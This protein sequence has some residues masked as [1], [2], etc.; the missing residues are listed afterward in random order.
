MD[1]YE[2]TTD[3]PIYPRSDLPLADISYFNT[4]SW[5]SKDKLPKTWTTK[6][7]DRFY[8]PISKD[9]TLPKWNSE[10]FYNGIIH[11]KN[12]QDNNLKLWHFIRRR[13]LRLPKNDILIDYQMNWKDFTCSQLKFLSH[14][15][16]YVNRLDSMQNLFSIFGTRYPYNHFKNSNPDDWNDN[17]PKGGIP[18]SFSRY[19]MTAFSPNIFGSMIDASN[20]YFPEALG[21]FY[22]DKLLQQAVSRQAKDDI[23]RKR[24]HLIT[25][26]FD[27]I[28]RYC[29]YYE[30][31]ERPVHLSIH[32]DTHFWKE[33]YGGPYHHRWIYSLYPTYFARNISTINPR[34]N[35]PFDNNDLFHTWP[36]WLWL[37]TINSY[38]LFYGIYKLRQ[39]NKR[40]T[41]KWQ[42]HIMQDIYMNHYEIAQD[43]REFKRNNLIKYFTKWIPRQYFLGTIVSGIVLKSYLESVHLVE[44]SPKLEPSYY[45]KKNSNW[46]NKW[47]S[48]IENRFNFTSENEFMEKN[49]DLKHYDLSGPN[50]DT[51]I[52][53]DNQEYYQKSFFSPL[54]AAQN[55]HG[56]TFFGSILAIQTLRELRKYGI[57]RTLPRALIR[58]LALSSIYLAFD[59]FRLHPYEIFRHA[60]VEALY[61]DWT[62]IRDLAN[63]TNRNSSIFTRILEETMTNRTMSHS[64]KT[65]VFNTLVLKH[66]HSK[67]KKDHDGKRMSNY[68]SDQMNFSE[69]KYNIDYF[70]CYNLKVGTSKEVDGEQEEVKLEKESN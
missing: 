15:E 57:I 25:L 21:T 5:Y 55:H 54:T 60:V 16:N 13:S 49:I 32:E 12:Y 6:W 62:K 68:F 61:L 45:Y 1:D 59:Y 39:Q 56:L 22:G 10:L 9:G 63:E 50:R 37:T 70:I 64:W 29:Q 18:F 48:F 66:V 35:I 34:D 51:F 27:R 2:T 41:I 30:V 11:E 33:V 44:N 7:N 28:K 14:I 20:F 38:V 65:E 52:R 67:L 53:H 47:P 3:R 58:S 8:A 43:T 40:L 4:K 46:Y 23:K 19:G 24:E 69:N 36:K 17:L 31:R 26:F 42:K